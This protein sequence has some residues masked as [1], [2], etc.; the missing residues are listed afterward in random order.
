MLLLP[1][2]LALAA[3]ALYFDCFSNKL[4][5]TE[6]ETSEY[7]VWTASVTGLTME[8]SL[9]A[10]SLYLLCLEEA[11]GAGCEATSSPSCPLTTNAQHCNAQ[12]MC[13]WEDQACVAKPLVSSSSD[14]SAEQEGDSKCCAE[15]WK[16]C[17]KTSAFYSRNR[18]N[19]GKIAQQ[20][21]KAKQACGNP[22]TK[23]ELCGEARR[24]RNC[25]AHRTA[26]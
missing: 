8:C 20:E 5:Q 6:C 14:N 15:S 25:A 12:Q 16:V 17:S 11:S 24:Q 9:S 23:L 26:D 22:E 4:S 10:Q 7:C 18:A 1:L 3:Q 19:R 13:A 2:V 21:L